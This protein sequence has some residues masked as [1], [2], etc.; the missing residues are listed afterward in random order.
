ML[1]A[2]CALAL[3]AG[4]VAAQ[5]IEGCDGQGNATLLTRGRCDIGSNFKFRMGGAPQA[6]YILRMDFGAG[7]TDVP[8]VGEFCL[9]FSDDLQVLGEGTLNNRGLRAVF[10]SIP[11]DPGLVGQLLAFQAEIQDASAPNGVAISNGF[12]V[13]LCGSGNKGNVCPPCTGDQGCTPGYWK[14]HPQAWPFTPFMPSDPISSVFTIPECL[15]DCSPDLASTSLIK[16]LD[17]NGG[18]GICGSAR[19]L[20]RAAIASALNASHPSVA[21]PRTLESILED[22]DAALAECSRDPM[23]DLGA[24]LDS[25]NNRGCPLNN[26]G[27]SDGQGDPPVVEDD[28][29][30]GVLR[31]GYTHIVFYEGDFPVDLTV[32]ACDAGDQA[33]IGE[34][35]FSFDPDNLPAFPIGDENLTVTDVNVH[36]GALV[37]YVTID[38]VNFSD[39]GT[40]PDSTTL[41]V[42]AGDV[43]SERTIGTSCDTPIGPGYKFNPV[44]IE[45]VKVIEP[46]ALVGQGT[47]GNK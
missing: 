12:F 32:S 26:D 10:Y 13:E 37:I 46:F 21:Y 3:L 28:C 8:G 41:K 31:L 16:G 15:A 19:I 14:N 22:T 47:G 2:L 45:K 7:P 38:G 34:A 30:R 25:D 1:A 9:D 43:T 39:N 17:F 27:S 42:A 29:D 36:A 20:L 40:L 5:C 6:P 23:L 11:D 18:G 35:N 4:P 44:F 33:L 24:A